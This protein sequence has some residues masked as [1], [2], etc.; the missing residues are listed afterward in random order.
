VS[1]LQF[2][3]PGNY[4]HIDRTIQKLSPSHLLIEHCYYGWFAHMLAKKHALKFIVHSHN[5]EY[6]RFRQMGKWWWPLLYQLEK[7]AHQWADLSLFKTE[8]DLEHAVSRFHLSRSKTMVVPYGLERIGVPDATRKEQARAAIVKRLEL[9]P[10]KRI[11]LFNG[12]LDYRPNA[13]ALE[14]IVTELIPELEKSSPDFNIVVTGRIVLPEYNYLLELSNP[15]Y[16]Y[17]G[18]VDDVESFLE[19]ADLFINPIT[20]GGG[21]KVKLMEA[22]SF[23]LP[24]ISYESGAQGIDRRCTGHSLDVIPDNDVRSMASLIQKRWRDQPAVPPAFF[25]TY[26]WDQITSGV[27]DRISAL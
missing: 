6:Q 10:S 7:K 26:H 8:E 20:E 25:A 21:V 9:D 18:H 19:G 24:V 14:H 4:Q 12:T 16:V 27:C 2:L 17:A 3:S 13:L 22:I 1:K 5:I 15:R 23:G 11:I